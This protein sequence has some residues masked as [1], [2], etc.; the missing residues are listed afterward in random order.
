M[1]NQEDILFRPF[2]LCGMELPNRVIMPP[3]TRSRAGQPGDVPNDMNVEYYRQRASA[4]LIIAEATQVSPQG[5]GYAFTPGIHSDAQVEGW[6]KVVDAVHGAGGR[7]ILQLWHVGRISHPELQPNGEKPVAPSAI[8]PEGAQTF[9]SAESG[10]V[11]I[12]E[13]RALETD[14]IPDVVEQFR[15]GAENA[16]RAGFDG[17]EIH[18]ANGYLLDQFLRTK[19]NQRTDHYGGSLEN[20]LRFPMMV[21]DAVAEV[22]GAD[23]VGVRVTPTGSFN[24]MADDNP[25]ETFAAFAKRLDE[26]GIAFIEVVEDSFQGN[27]VK[28]RPEEVIKA[29]QDNF[30]RTYIGNGHYTAEEARERIEADKCDLASFGR[31]FIANPDLPERFRRGAPLNEWDASTFYG[32]DE[33]G[34]TDYPFLES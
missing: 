3:L 28:G 10:M 17:V 2:M 4:G 18:A 15:Q 32:G 33:R 13:P 25:V 31:A 19:S 16:K 7:I 29:I 23:R 21:V 22:W 9:I 34:Y 6:R 1:A 8:K 24:D 20:R 30:K 26:A 12:P 11:D 5:K 27:L 14:E